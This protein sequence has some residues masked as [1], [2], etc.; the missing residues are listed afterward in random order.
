MKKQQIYGEAE[1]HEYSACSEPHKPPLK[2]LAVFFFC[3][4][5]GDRC[6]GEFRQAPWFRDVLRVLVSIHDNRIE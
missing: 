3:G 1:H 6:I 4:G 2:K 5:I